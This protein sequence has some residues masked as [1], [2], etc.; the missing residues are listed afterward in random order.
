MNRIACLCLVLLTISSVALASDVTTVLTR[1]VQGRLSE[2]LKATESPNFVQADYEYTISPSSTSF[3]LVD[4][5]CSLP[6]S[7][8]LTVEGH[9]SF[10]VRLEGELKSVDVQ[11]KKVN[12]E[13][14]TTNLFK[15]P[16]GSIGMFIINRGGRLKVTFTSSGK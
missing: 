3:F 9:S 8:W 15:F 1:E 11:M 2:A 13:K 14:W 12:D 4:V 6:S 5:D 16:D 7:F 10:D